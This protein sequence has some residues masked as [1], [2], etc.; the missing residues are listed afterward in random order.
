MKDDTPD[1]S[2]YT[3]ADLHDVARRVNKQLYPD[4][5]ALIMQ[6][7]ERREPGRAVEPFALPDLSLSEGCLFPLLRFVGGFMAVS[8]AIHYLKLSWLEDW[9]FVLGLMG[10]SYFA[11]FYD[12]ILRAP[13]EPVIFR[14]FFNQSLRIVLSVCGAAYLARVTAFVLAIILMPSD[15]PDLISGVP[16]Y[17][18]AEYLMNGFMVLGAIG[19]FWLWKRKRPN[20]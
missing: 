12:E 8:I 6:E 19:V 15:S 2:C 20:P 10:G 3:L 14:Y 7:L 13:G 9:G 11:F 4:R 17:E 5:Y 1:Y 16:D 18:T